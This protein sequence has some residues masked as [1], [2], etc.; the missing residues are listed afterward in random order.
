MLAVQIA[1]MVTVSRG[2]LEPINLQQLYNNWEVVHVVSISGFLP[3]TLVILSLH[4]VG[5]KSWYLTTLSIVTV[6]VSIGTLFMTGSFSP[7][8]KDM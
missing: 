3:V 7:T 4:S 5:K 2:Q 8:L 1:A 6:G